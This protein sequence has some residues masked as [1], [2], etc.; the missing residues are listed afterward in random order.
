MRFLKLKDVMH[1]TGLGRSTVYKYI[2]ESRFP[3][4]VTLGERNVAWVEDEVQ[5]WMLEKI[6]QRDMV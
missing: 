2:S 6:A 1:L 5:E 3:K 4:P